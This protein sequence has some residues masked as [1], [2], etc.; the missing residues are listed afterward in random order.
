MKATFSLNLQGDSQIQKSH[1]TVTGLP[2]VC[3]V[4]RQGSRNLY[5]HPSLSLASKGNSRR[6][7]LGNGNEN[8]TI[9]I[10]Q[11]LPLVECLLCD[12]HLHVLFLVLTTIP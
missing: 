12:G 6:T 10:I 8:S 7:G 2:R 3:S 1:P 9:V 5:L 4:W 11:Q